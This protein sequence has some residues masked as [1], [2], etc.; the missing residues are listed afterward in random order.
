MN[1]GL[2]SGGR[3]GYRLGSWAPKR[4]AESFKGET[5]REELLYAQHSHLD[6]YGNF[7]P[8]FCGGIRLGDWHDLDGVI[9]AIRE[10]DAPQMIEL[11]VREGPY[12]LYVRA[13]E[14][15]TYQPLAEGYVGKCH[16]C[17]DVR[18]HLVK[19]GA[20][21]ESLAPRHFYESF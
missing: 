21:S 1:Y 16:I 3:A 12:G 6:L 20:Y 17:V 18:T 7:I 8:A 9:K 14:D 10:E 4:P 5:C 15:Y 11:L 19:I 13:R 2:I